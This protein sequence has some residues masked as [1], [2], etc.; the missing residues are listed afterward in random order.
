MVG[1]MNNIVRAIVVIVIIAAIIV[2]AVEIFVQVAKRTTGF[3]FATA[4][5]PVPIAT[6]LI[7]SV[8]MTVEGP[9]VANEQFVSL[10]LTASASQRTLTI[11][12]TYANQTLSNQTLDNNTEAYSQFLDALLNAGY[13]KAVPGQSGTKVDSTCP[14]GSRY[15]YDAL[16]ASGNP[17]TSLW[18]TSCGSSGASFDGDVNM[19]NQLFKA[20]FPSL[21]QL[22]TQFPQLSQLSW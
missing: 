20:Q 13:T 7:N 11:F 2:A 9:I 12:V 6:N 17:L 8:R 22:E 14:Q 18:S 21:N 3:P 5:T 10:T 15:I 4:P 16:D 19:V 1:K